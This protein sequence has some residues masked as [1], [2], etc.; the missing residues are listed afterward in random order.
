M[1]A[2]L[3]DECLDQI[4]RVT[5]P[6]CPRCGNAVKT[7]GLCLRCRTQPLHIE[8]MRSVVYFG[9]TLREAIHRFKYNG[10]TALAEPLGGLMAH[11]WKKHPIPTDV[12]VPVPLHATRLRERGYNQATLLA[13]EMARQE[14]L[15]MDETILTR[16]RATAPQVELNAQQRKENVRDAFL[17]TKDNLT[18]KRVLLVDD[19]CTTGSTLEA[20]AVA[21]KK[22]GAYDVW[23]L[24]LARA[25]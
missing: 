18:S 17:C 7:K 24:T 9:G 13:R 22:A 19:V 4:P 8:R 14:G 25:H 15:A 10:L 11:Y 23:A 20:C 5:P 16:Q 12:V 2:W 3:C 6:I 21:M 1:D